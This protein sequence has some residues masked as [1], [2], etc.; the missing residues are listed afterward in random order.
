[1]K[2]RSKRIL[3]RTSPSIKRSDPD[4]TTDTV[5]S[6]LTGVSTIPDSTNSDILQSD[7]SDLLAHTPNSNIP[8]LPCSVQLKNILDFD[9]AELSCIISKCTAKNVKLVISSLQI[10]CLPVI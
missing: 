1:M 10:L 3:A 2:R 7:D 9:D 6:V 8:L 5:S 4:D